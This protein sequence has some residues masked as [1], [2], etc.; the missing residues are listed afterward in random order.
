VAGKAGIFFSSG[1][2]FESVL[3]LASKLPILIVCAAGLPTHKLASDI[4]VVIRP[5]T[6]LSG[7]KANLPM[8]RSL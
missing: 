7:V 4:D 3:A 1:S 2:G 5:C 6:T 8:S